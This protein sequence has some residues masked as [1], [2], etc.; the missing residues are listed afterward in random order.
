MMNFQ[1]RAQRLLQRC[2]QLAEFT[3]IDY[4]LCRT[5]LSPEHQAC[6]QQVSQ[7][8]QAAGMAS[9]QDAAGNIWGRYRGSDPN[10]GTLILGSHLDTVVNAGKYDGILG[11]LAA[12]EIVDQLHQNNQQLAFNIDVVGFGRRRRHPIWH[13][14]NWQPRSSWGVGRQLERT[15]GR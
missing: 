5:Y 2:D 4:G 10:A 12:I 8:Y 15:Q 11:V 14:I 3:S 6:N 13:H 9:W 7:W 1:T